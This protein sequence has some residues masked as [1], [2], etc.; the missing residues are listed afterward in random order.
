MDHELSAPWRK[1]T[2]DGDGP[3]EGGGGELNVVKSKGCRNDGRLTAFAIGLYFVI[4][5]LVIT[6]KRLF[7]M[8]TVPSL[9]WRVYLDIP[10][11]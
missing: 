10:D 3:K 1:A 11:P 9:V 6:E 4:N 8:P 5:L 7:Q 2:K